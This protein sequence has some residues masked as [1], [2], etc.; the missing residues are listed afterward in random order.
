MNFYQDRFYIDKIINDSI[1]NYKNENDQLKEK[2]FQLENKIIEITNE[3][4]Q[5]KNHFYYM[6][7]GDGYYEAEENFKKLSLQS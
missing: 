3:N 1:Q 7:G 2:I 6:P 5:L 4:E